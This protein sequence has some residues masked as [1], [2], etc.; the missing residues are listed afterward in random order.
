MT[1]ISKKLIGSIIIGTVL[2][3]PVIFSTASA[4][5]TVVQPASGAYSGESIEQLTSRKT[6]IESMADIDAKVKINAVND[7]EQ[8]ISSLELYKSISRKTNDLSQLI[9][10]APKRI[11]ELQEKLA[12]TDTKNDKVQSHSQHKGTP[13][14][15]EQVRLIEAELATAQT[16]L[17]QWRDRLSAEKNAIHQIPEKIADSM[18][19]QKE[20]RL[21]LE[22]YV[23]V[24]ET[25]VLGHASM[26][27]LK[28]EQAK[29]NTEINYNKQRQRGY[30]LLIE[31]FNAEL[32]LDQK[33]ANSLEQQLND[34]QVYLQGIRQKEAVQSQIDTQEAVLKI[35]LQPKII[36]D[37][38]D[39]NIKLS[40]ELETIIKNE[41]KLTEKS[42]RYKSELKTLKEEFE[43]AR[44]RVDI[45]L[46]NEVIGLA[47]RAQRLNLP[48]ADEYFVD[49]K[50]F[51]TK[52]SKASERQIAL[53]LLMRELDNSDA[54]LDTIVG[55][56]SLIS[57]EDRKSLESKIRE[58]LNNRL[59]IIQKS[60]SAYD[61]AIK[62]I[63]DIEFTKEKLVD[64][65]EDFEELLNRHLLWI[66]S[67]K[68]VRINDVQDLTVSMGWFLKPGN[69]ISLLHDLGRSFASSPFFWI[70][71]I[72]VF[73]PLSF[74]RP[75]TKKQLK[76]TADQIDQQ[77]DDSFWLTIKTL[78][79]T[80]ILAAAWPFLLWFP[81]IQL[82]GLPNTD[83]FSTGIASGLTYASFILAF[84]LLFY[85]VCRQY[86]LA[87]KHFQWPEVI[88]KTLIYNLAWLIPID[89]VSSFFLGA[90][91]AVPKFKYSDSLAK[92][93]I[94]ILSLAVSIFAAR[95]FRFKGGITSLA[96][97]TKP[98]SWFCRLRYLWYP[99]AILFPLC[100]L[101]LAVSG[102]YYSALE[103]RSLMYN[104]IGLI[105]SLIV[106]NDMA[107]RALKLARQRVIAKN[108][109]TAKEIHK[110]NISPERSDSDSENKNQPPLTRT[111]V[112]IKEID[113]QAR[114]LLKL[115]IFVIGLFGV[116]AIWKDIFPAFGI[117]QDIQFWSYT[118]V[119]GGV[120]KTVPITPASIIITVIV[121]TT[122]IVAV[123]NLPGLLEIILLNNLPMDPGARYAYSTVLRY[124][125]TAL[126]IIIALNIL[127]IRWER[128][129]WL[130][131]ALSVGIGFG[132]QEIVANFISGLIVLF[133]RPF[134]IGDTITVG[135]IN[136][137]VK[138]IQIRATTIEDWDRKELIVPNKDFITGTLL[139][140]TLSDH[141]I[142][143]KIPVGIAYG[144]DT[145]LAE[146]LMLKAAKNNSLVLKTPPATA[147]FLGFGDN[148]LNFE[149]RVFVKSLDDYI[150]MLHQMNRTIDQ[151]FRKNG[152]TIAFPQRDLHLDKGPIDIRLVSGE[153]SNPAMG[154]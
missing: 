119:V 147:V 136:G 76:I 19:R 97:E 30:N 39:L 92:F 110:E 66:R 47:L 94:I 99:L 134:R 35:P 31:L 124:T 5:Q 3:Y 34:L 38:F 139:N 93:A 52:M 117:L 28:A 111:I 13:D 149:V 120:E 60:K 140:W 21:Q 57:D 108:A 37:Q 130:V 26:L 48:D 126:G 127:G 81:A 131:A 56:I 49:S 104:S 63:Q 146:K 69:W 61:R 18:E 113:E 12:R 107:L 46:L 20:I 129:Q 118:T 22:S 148:T 33:M 58:V 153:A 51:R 41:I 144:S 135:E 105:L 11:K 73:L 123:R 137:T 27:F 145:D 84:W 143:I 67:S 32:T 138:R 29:I 17:Q 83:Q 101:G 133:E 7:I 112:K 75:W 80:I 106:L 62:L 88:R 102:Y 54:L 77:A 6:A 115:S 90:M 122:T 71:G 100:I 103:I 25:D 59:D 98:D 109:M 125:I 85:T 87:Q 9:R 96:M 91:V 128:L 152:I 40:A 43:I 42:N 36:Q 4:Q 78:G 10:S 64:T 86:G 121:V 114:S 16:G 82:T 154:E 132:L 50:S 72:I 116:W 65:A 95:I 24:A 15:E 1:K 8:A 151:E 45:D 142:R 79:I 74:S 55:S 89:T 70:F 141:I 68:P 14:L 2:L 53:D 150:P 44:K 23:N